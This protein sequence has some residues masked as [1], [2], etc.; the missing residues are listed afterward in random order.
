MSIIDGKQTAFGPIGNLPFVF[1][2]ADVEDDRDSVFIVGADVAVVRIG[3]VGGQEAVLL[4]GV[5][6]REDFGNLARGEFGR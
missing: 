6:R 4:R 5:P 3:R 2:S 1:R